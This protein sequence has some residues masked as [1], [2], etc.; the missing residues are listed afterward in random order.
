MRKDSV[1]KRFIY[2]RR[3]LDGGQSV[4]MHDADAFFRP[5][6]LRDLLGY[7]GVLGATDFAVSDN[8]ARDE[9]F[10]DL[11]WGL[12]WMAANQRTISM[13]ECLLGMW[14]HYAF[15]AKSG[16]FFRRSQPRI[17]H[18]IEIHHE[19]APYATAI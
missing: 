14:D 6:G 16:A 7:L 2:A 4:L 13:L 18:L 17:N 1:R 15:T 5:G 12:V 8:G 19:H 9:V 10:D 3:L 11:N